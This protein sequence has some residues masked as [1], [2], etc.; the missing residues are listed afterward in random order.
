MDTARRVGRASGWF[1]AVGLTSRFFLCEGDGFGDDFFGAAGLSIGRAVIK[2]GEKQM[3]SVNRRH[4]VPAFEGAVIA[5]ESELDGGREFAF[6][7]H[8]REDLFGNLFSAAFAR[9]GIF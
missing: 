1:V 9:S 5:R 7:F 3:A 8:G 6:G 4:E 2:D